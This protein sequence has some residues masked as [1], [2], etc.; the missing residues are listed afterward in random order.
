MRVSCHQD[1]AGNGAFSL[2]MLA[3]FEDVLREAPWQYRRLFW[4]TGMVGQVLYLEAEA[5]QMRGTGIGCY[6]DDAV[7]ML[8]GI[9]DRRF[10]NLYHFTVGRPINDPRLQSHPPY[11]HLGPGR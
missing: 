1:I 11:V 2:A 8:A 10:Q 6:F 4:E 9:G 7:H 5:R 3:R